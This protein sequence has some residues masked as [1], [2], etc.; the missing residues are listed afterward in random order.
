MEAFTG[1]TAK[2]V[3]QDIFAKVFMMT[4]CAIYAFP[5]EQKVK[6]EYKDNLKTKAED[7]TAGKIT[8]PVAKAMAVLSKPDRARLWQIVSSKTEDITLLTEAV[9][10]LDKHN[11]IENCEKEAK[12]ILERAW[13]KLDPLVRD[14]MVKLNLRAFSWFVLERT[15]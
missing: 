5:I 10:L 15:Y 2:A 7:I 9:A 3:K 11:T 14:S 4:L 12:N 8:Y 1:K 13:R 6:K